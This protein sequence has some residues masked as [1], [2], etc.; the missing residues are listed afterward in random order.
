MIATAARGLGEVLL[1][2]LRLAEVSPGEAPVFAL[3]AGLGGLALVML[4]LSWSGLLYR[5][6]ILVAPIG[7]LA[8]KFFGMGFD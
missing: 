1:S 8:R 6:V 4:G 3:G 5:P 7:S 2:R